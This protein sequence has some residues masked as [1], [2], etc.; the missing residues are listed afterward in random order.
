MQTVI[1]F[2]MNARKASH[3]NNV[4]IVLGKNVVVGICLT[5]KNKHETCVLVDFQVISSGFEPLMSI[6]ILVEN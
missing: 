5:E 6:T 3:Q 1:V 2:L 4:R